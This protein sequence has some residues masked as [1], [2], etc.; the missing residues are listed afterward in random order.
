LELGGNDP[1][2]ILQDAI[3]DEAH[4]DRLFAAIY[5]TTGQICMN[6]KRVYVHASRIDEVV[7]GLSARLQKTKLGYG[8]DAD[9]TMGPLHSPAQKTFVDEL[10][11]EAKDSGAT[12]LEFG[13]LPG[14]DMKGGNFV[15]PAIVINPD[16]KLRVV[17]EEQF[18]PVI[19]IIPFETEED[20]VKAANDSWAGLAGSVWTANAETA[21][22]VGSQM[23][24]GYVWV[25]DHGA[26][27]LDLR[28]PFGGMKSSGIGREQ[29]IEGIRAFQDT[30]AIA[31]LDAATLATMHH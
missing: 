23:V 2:V 31:H 12:V 24:C 15:R 4:L 22:R 29:G 21:N 20:A 27:R 10:I 8:L 9:T 18:G 14:G 16:L 6:A 13:A 7:S 28:A 17:T 11:Q 3:L 25:N 5:D 1:A 30:R 19:P 26:T